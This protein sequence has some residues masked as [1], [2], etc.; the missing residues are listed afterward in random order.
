MKGDNSSEQ[1]SLA[2]HGDK[3]ILNPSHPPLDSKNL[4]EHVKFAKNT[5]VT[6]NSQLMIDIQDQSRQ[7]NTSKQIDTLGL[8]PS[9][10]IGRNEQVSTT[11]EMVTKQS[12]KASMPTEPFDQKFQFKE[13]FEN[14]NAFIS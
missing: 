10:V 13:G 7:R 14:G 12:G 8:N 2:A 5:E 3:V 9:P 1:Y 11:S 6:H 4:Q